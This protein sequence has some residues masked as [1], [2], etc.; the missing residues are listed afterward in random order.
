MDEALFCFLVTYKG[1]NARTNVRMRYK[2]CL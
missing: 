2:S 1:T